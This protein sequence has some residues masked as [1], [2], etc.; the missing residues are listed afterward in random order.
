MEARGK[1]D[2]WIRQK[3]E[4]LTVLREQA[5][6]QSV[7]SSNRIE[8]VTIAVDRLRPVVLGKAQAQGSFGRGI[9]RIQTGFGMDFFAEAHDLHRARNHAATSRLSSGRFLWRCG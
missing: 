6:I 4:V 1:Q 2:L 9:G 8:G 7:E 5:I 3:P